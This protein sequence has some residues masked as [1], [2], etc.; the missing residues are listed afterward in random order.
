MIVMST[1]VKLLVSL[2]VLILLLFGTGF[3]TF[4][5]LN[6]RNQ[7][8]PDAVAALQ[9]DTD[10]TVARVAE[11]DWYEFTPTAA[12]PTTGLILYPGGFVDPVAYAPMARDIAQQGYLVVLDPMLLNLA[13][14]G[15][16]S[17]D[18]I[19]AAHPD[20]T[21]WAIGGHSL[22]GAMAAEYINNNPGAVT[23]LA[24]W[25]AYPAETTDLSAQPVNVFSIYGDADGVA[26]SEDV[27][28]AADR[29]PP[30]TTFVVIPG[31][32]HTQF[33]SYGEGLQRGDNPAGIDRNGQRA[34]IVAATAQMLHQIT[35][36]R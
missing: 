36:T 7:A 22:G 4:A 26:S 3:L 25:A 23:G 2:V 8:R 29:L 19:I 6:A 5:V 17:A 20:I 28:G 30:D 27:L 9:S 10:V 15:V 1:R 14:T 35:P 11:H 18:T 31:G 13:V 16:E 33:G 32:N 21:A 34:A 12:P 24:L